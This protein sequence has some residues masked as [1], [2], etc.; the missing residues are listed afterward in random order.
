MDREFVRLLDE[1]RAPTIY[2]LPNNIFS[3]L[4]YDHQFDWRINGVNP[5]GKLTIKVIANF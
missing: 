2:A 5:V 1:A 3:R 4:L